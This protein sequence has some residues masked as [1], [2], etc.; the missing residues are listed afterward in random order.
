MISPWAVLCCAMKWL[1]FVLWSNRTKLW[2]RVYLHNAAT[3][4]MPMAALYAGQVHVFS[5]SLSYASGTDAGL[6]CCDSA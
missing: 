1:A 4:C 3:V 2:M 6:V 5:K